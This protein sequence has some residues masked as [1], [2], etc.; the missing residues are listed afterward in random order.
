MILRYGGAVAAALLLAAPAFAQP[1]GGSPADAATNAVGPPAA[2]APPAPA[3]TV[4]APTASAPPTTA[5]PKGG[6]VGPEIPP[7]PAGQGEVVFFRP[8]E[9]QGWAIFF[10]IRENGKALGKLTNGV[11][12][13][14]VAS[15]GPHTY[16][17]ATENQDSLKLVVE[18][19]EIYYVA[20]TVTM[21][22][23]VGE[24]NI[25]PSDQEEFIRAAH[26][27]KQV[28][29]ATDTAAGA[30]SPNAG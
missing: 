25:A 14:S 12:F 22:V 7:P 6:F 26:K 27:L 4:P 24:A 28:K 1:A 11:Y 3:P 16:T 19:G 5:P 10:N 30:T 23:F 2:G 13:V 29:S 18:P 8:N 20:G 21:G 17:A 9:Y 15:P